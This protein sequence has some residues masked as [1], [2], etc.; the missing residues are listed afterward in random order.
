MNFKGNKKQASL[1]SVGSLLIASLLAFSCAPNKSSEQ[2][3]SGQLDSN[4][5]IIGGVLAD[6]KYQSSN[7]VVGLLITSQNFLGQ[8]Q[9]SICTGTLLD[10][11]IVLTA[12]HCIAEQGLSSVIVFFAKDM[13]SATEDRVRFALTGTIHEQYQTEIKPNDPNAALANWHDIAMLVLNEDAPADVKPA[14]LAPAGTVLKKGGTLTL[15]GYG[16]TNAVIRKEVKKNGRSIIQE[17]A[18]VGDGTLRKVD[19]IV[20]SSLVNNDN[21]IVLDQKKKGACHGD[22]GGPAFLKNADGSVVQV[23]VTSRGLEKLGNCNVQSVYTSTIAHMEWIKTTSVD[24][25]KQAEEILKQAAEDKTAAPVQE[26][27][28][29]A[30]VVPV[31][32]GTK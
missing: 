32:A 25:L 11:K 21:E 15:A 6:D 9:Q 28:G 10:K 1:R 18:G 27:P 26:T 8:E 30:P 13:Q 19:G 2:Q 5:N 31:V 22:S 20:I 7:G 16:I 23:G 4:S 12:A 3:Y 17:L 29:A 14:Q 24:L